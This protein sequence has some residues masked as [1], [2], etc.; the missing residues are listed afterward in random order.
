[1]LRW[2]KSGR[3]TLLFPVIEL[4]LFLLFVS[5][6]HGRNRLGQRM[7]PL[8][9]RLLRWLRLAEIAGGWRIPIF[10]LRTAL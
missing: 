1:M 4:L 3:G 2:F 7:R 6:L 5:V 10:W 9:G 8:L